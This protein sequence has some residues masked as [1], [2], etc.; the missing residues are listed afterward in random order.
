MAA[1]LT[2]H[3]RRATGVCLL[4]ATTDG[5]DGP[6]DAAGAF[7]TSETPSLIAAA[8]IDPLEALR[9]HNCYPALDAAG[10][11]IRTGLTG[12]NVMDLILGWVPARPA[13]D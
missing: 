10:A 5:R 13:K 12:T 2:L 8:G 9:H 7:V 3:E 6:T 11:L 4:V 1:A